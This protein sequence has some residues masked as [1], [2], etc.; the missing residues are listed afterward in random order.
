MRAWYT[1]GESVEEALRWHHR[2]RRHPDRRDISNTRLERPGQR[3]LLLPVA[4]GRQRHV[5][6]HKPHL[7]DHR[8]GRC[9][10]RSPMTTTSP[11]AWPA[12]APPSRWS[13]K[14]GFD[15]TSASHSGVNTAFTLQ[16]YFSVEPTL[17]F[18]DVRDSVLDVTSGTVTAVRRTAP[19]AALATAAGSERS[20]RPVLRP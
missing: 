14:A 11:R 6:R 13:P 5:R 7:R 17:G 18:V 20:Y 16:L 1:R 2:S 10:S 9:A 8:G 4:P 3:Q 15:N 12:P 19:K